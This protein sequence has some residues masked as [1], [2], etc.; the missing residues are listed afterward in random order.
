MA[1]RY[2]VSNNGGENINRESNIEENI[3]EN[4]VEK[5]RMNPLTKTH[6]QVRCSVQCL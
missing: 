3:H 2:C 6:A 1:V 5:K 4:S